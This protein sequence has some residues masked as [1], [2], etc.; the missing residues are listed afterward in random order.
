MG[1]G[2]SPDSS[3]SPK[4]PSERS[5][6]PGGLAGDVQVF[7]DNPLKGGGHRCMIPNLAAGLPSRGW[8]WPLEER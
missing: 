8:L 6:A 3:P 7:V 5:L 4:S 2:P 1:E